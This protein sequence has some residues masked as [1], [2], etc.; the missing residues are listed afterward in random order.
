MQPVHAT[1]EC[2][3]FHSR[4]LKRSEGGKMKANKNGKCQ[5]NDTVIKIKKVELYEEWILFELLKLKKLL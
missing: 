4:N 2:M 1:V 3:P 5:I